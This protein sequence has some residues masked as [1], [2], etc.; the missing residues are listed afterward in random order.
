[1]NIWLLSHL[2]DSPSREI[3]F[4]A[5]EKCHHT[6][7]VVHPAKCEVSFKTEL[8]LRC[9]DTEISRPDVVFVRMGSSAPEGSVHVVRLLERNGVRCI[10]SSESIAHTRDKATTF[11]YLSR[12][13]VPIPKTIY[14]AAGASYS[15]VNATLPG[16]KWIIKLP[17]SSKGKGVMLAE[18]SA[19]LRA[20]LDLFGS[21]GQAV[22][23]QEF[24][25]TEDSSDTRVFVLGQKAIC[26]MKRRGNS[27]DFR[28]NLHCGGSPEQIDLTRPLKECAEAAAKAL[29]LD[30]AGVDILEGPD[31]PL[32]IEV[33]SSPGLFGLQSVTDKNVG[34]AIVGYLEHL[35]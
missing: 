34:E 11:H 15:E 31:G 10:N 20:A 14:H 24:I 16:P 19:G 26:A 8:D 35:A 21:L 25:P 6:V 27:E 18:S 5:A 33:N 32:V 22:L 3:F 23:I 13:K 7:C 12:K 1:M 9:D 2:A 4:D 17:V 30:I 28:S 29:G